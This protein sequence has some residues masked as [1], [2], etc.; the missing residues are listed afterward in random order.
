MRALAAVA[1]SDVTGWSSGEEDEALEGASVLIVEVLAA[2]SAGALVDV[3]TAAVME[4]AAEAHVPAWAVMGV[5]RPLP[6]RLFRAAAE[7]AGAGVD[8]I[9]LDAFALAI[10]LELL[11]R[12][13]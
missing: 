5:G 12:S 8:Q 6:E 1:S 4:A 3:G 9:D 11:R 2:A 10:G 13:I 7:R